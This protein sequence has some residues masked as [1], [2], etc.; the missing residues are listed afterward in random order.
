VVRGL[1]LLLGAQAAPAT[2]RPGAGSAVVEGRVV[3][4]EGSPVRARAEEAGA[5]VDDDGGL[6][7]LRTV[8]A[9]TDGAPGR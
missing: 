3:V 1:T 6:V 4:P 8:A 9:A 2:V 7:L 5:S